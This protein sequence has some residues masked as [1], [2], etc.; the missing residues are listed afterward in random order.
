MKRRGERYLSS[1]RWALAGS[2]MLTGSL[3]TSAV[4]AAPTTQRDSRVWS[5]ASQH[6]E[7]QL[8]LLEQ[9]VNTDSGT[10]DQEGGRKIADL[11][12]QQLRAIGAD[13]T[14]SPAEAPGLAPN[15]VA[16]FTGSGKGRLLLIG[17]LD[18]V[19]EPGTAAKRPFRMDAQRAYGP[20]IID[21]KGGVVEAVFA[22]K[23]L[24]EIG[25][26]DF[27]KLDFALLL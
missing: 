23:I 9:V 13:V 24:H 14:T 26:K 1:A 25:F 6:R 2:L 21:E 19:F 22:L 20:G 3:L 27:R 11:L 4:G 10:G 15:L 5:L 17:H 18:T 16:T 7:E 12:A 8:K